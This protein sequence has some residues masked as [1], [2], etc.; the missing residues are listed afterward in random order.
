MPESLRDLTALFRKLGASDPASWASSQKDE[1]I[2]QLQ[3]YLFLR[4]AWRK[5]VSE[6]DAAWIDREIEHA[7][8]DPDAPFAGVGR[9]ILRLRALG[10][11]DEDLTD[12]VRGMQAQVLF[13]FCY[14]LGDPG[15]LEDEVA[16]VEWG[17]FQIDQDGQPVEALDLLHEDVLGTDPTGREMRPRA[18]G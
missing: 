7:A 15:D 5:V 9:A 2:P 11:S 10:A 12:L 8:R 13:S 16:D 17:L 3:R 18:R 4:Q 6:G 1:N 14:L